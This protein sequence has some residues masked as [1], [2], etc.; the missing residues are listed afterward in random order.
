MEERMKKSLNLIILVAFC[1]VTLFSL[2]PRGCPD[3]WNRLS[4]LLDRQVLPMKKTSSSGQFQLEL[5]K[6]RAALE[7]SGIADRVSLE[8]YVNGR[9]IARLGE[10]AMT[11]RN[12][13]GR[14]LNMNRSNPFRLSTRTMNQLKSGNMKVKLL[15]RNQSRTEKITKTVVLKYR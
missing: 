4:E 8:L 3:C 10:F 6:I 12:R 14:Y 1:S 2:Q 15:I 11:K 5:S 9:R 7:R 13:R